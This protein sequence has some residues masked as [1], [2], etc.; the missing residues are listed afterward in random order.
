DLAAWTVKAP[1]SGDHRLFE[2][3]VDSPVPPFVPFRMRQ[4]LRRPPSPPGWHMLGRAMRHPHRFRPMAAGL[5]LMAPG[6]HDILE[7]VA[8]LRELHD[9]AWPERDLLICAVRRRDG[10]RVVFGQDVST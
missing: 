4:L 1:L 6:R 3:I 8:A 7:Q 10:S 5:A 9:V 2:R